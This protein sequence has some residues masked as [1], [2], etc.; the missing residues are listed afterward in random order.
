MPRLLSGSALV[1][2]TRETIDTWRDHYNR[3]RPHRSIGRKPPAVFA[4]QVA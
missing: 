4:Q 3:V 1:E 2:D